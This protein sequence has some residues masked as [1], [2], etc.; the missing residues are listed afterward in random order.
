[1]INNNW[2]DVKSKKPPKATPILIYNGAW[3]GIGY[4]KINYRLKISGEPEW[5]E[6]NGE[7]IHTPP[8]HWQP[9]PPPPNKQP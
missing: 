2:I 6:E 7:Y 4:Y 9:L 1:M 3:V 8:T 5:S